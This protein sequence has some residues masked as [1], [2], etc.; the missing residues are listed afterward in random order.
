ML[1]MEREQFDFLE[2]GKGPVVGDEVGPPVN[3][4]VV[5]FENLELQEQS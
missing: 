5:R 1:L 2:L 3:C 4:L